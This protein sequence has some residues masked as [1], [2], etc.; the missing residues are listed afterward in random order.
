MRVLVVSPFFPPQNAAGGVRAWS[1]ARYFARAGEDVTVI[2]T[3]KR[4]HQQGLEL[5]RSGFQT[6]ELPFPIPRFLSRVRDRDAGGS[7]GEPVAE[8]DVSSIGPVATESAGNGFESARRAPLW[9]RF[10]RSIRD[11]T[12]IFCGVRMPDLTDAWVQPAIRAAIDAGPWDAVVSTSGPYTSHRVAHELRIGGHAGFWVADYRDAWTER[13]VFTGLFPFTVVERRLERRMLASADLISA[14][15]APIAERLA[16]RS[17]RDA[18]VIWNGY[19][20]ELARA[21]DPAPALPRDG[22]ARIVYTGSIYRGKRDPDPLLAALGILASR[23]NGARRVELVVAGG[24]RDLWLERARALGAGESIR[25]LGEVSRDLALRIQRDADLLAFLDWCGPEEGMVTSKLLEYVFAE[26][27][28]IAIGPR[29]DTIPIE[30][31]SRLGRGIAA[32]SDAAA[33][34]RAIE[35]ALRVGRAAYHG[36]RA[37]IAEYSRAHQALRLLDEIRARRSA[38]PGNCANVNCIAPLE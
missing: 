37:G 18:V 1:F 8:S 13:D 6:I 16:A 23:G 10:A 21:I 32:G 35:G 4:E 3:R 19:D 15:S 25:H 33:V 17:G 11:R 22:V 31:L 9:L 36:D 14:V 38:K 24:N 26:A 27:P 30:V 29:N 28:I 20:E 2:T 34:A 7:H 5:D 12:G